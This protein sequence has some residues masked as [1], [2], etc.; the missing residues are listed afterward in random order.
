MA[1]HDGLSPLTAQRR[2]QFFRHGVGGAP[3]SAERSRAHQRRD[4]RRRRAGKAFEIVA[5]FKN[6]DEAALCVSFRNRHQQRGRSGEIGKQGAQNQGPI[7]VDR[8]PLIV[9]SYRN[10]GFRII[11]DAIVRFS[12]VCP[13]ALCAVGR[14]SASALQKSDI[15]KALTAPPYYIM[16]EMVD[17]RT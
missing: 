4:M 8:K 16:C 1:K 14:T 9:I 2:L 5:A 17:R 3:E 6:R 12:V 7:L 13:L 15:K 10:T 11:T